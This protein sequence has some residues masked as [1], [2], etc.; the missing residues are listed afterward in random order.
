MWVRLS[1]HMVGGQNTSQAQMGSPKCDSTTNEEATGNLNPIR[2][3]ARP[4]SQ[5]LLKKLIH[6]HCIPGLCKILPL[7]CNPN[8]CLMLLQIHQSQKN[9]RPK[10]IQVRNICFFRGIQQ[11]SHQIPLQ[12]LANTVSINFS[13]HNLNTKGESITNKKLSDHTLNPVKDWAFTIF[14]IL[15]TQ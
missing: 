10:T 9:N 5:V 11:L 1:C 14:C 2:E 12:H 3:S 4:P 6:G 13:L 15:E 7:M 8:I